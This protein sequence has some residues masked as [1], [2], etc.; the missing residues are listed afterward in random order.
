VDEQTQAREQHALVIL[1]P[2]AGRSSADEVR[3]LLDAALSA[4]HWSHEVYET[5]GDDDI[6]ALLAQAQTT[7]CD[8]VVAAGGDGTVS[9]V[10]NALV[11]TTMPLGIIPSG[12]ANVLALELGIPQN[13]EQAAQLLVQGHTHRTLDAMRLGDQHFVLQI[14]IGLDALMIQQTDRQAKRRWGRLAYL[15]TLAAQLV[16]YQPQR[17]TILIDGRRLRPR[18]WQILVANVGLLGAPPLRWGPRIEPDDGEIDL[19]IIHIRTLLDYARIAVQVLRGHQRTAPNMHYI[20]VREHVVIAADRSLPV[21]ADGEIV[22]QTP[23]R[24]SVV[25]HS[26]TLRVPLTAQP[27]S[28]QRLIKETPAMSDE[29]TDAQAKQRISD[30]LAEAV[31]QI[32]TPAQADQVIGDV[33]RATADTTEGEAAAELPGEPTPPSAAAALDDAAQTPAEH[34]PQAV[35]LEAARQVAGANGADEQAIIDAL[36]RVTA[37]DAATLPAAHERERRLLQDALLRRLGPLRTVDTGIFL[38]INRLP[39]PAVLN[40]LMQWLSAGMNRGDAVMVGL[41]AAAFFDRP[42]GGQA[43]REVLPALWL[44]A[45]TVEYPIKGVFRRRRPF[46]AIVRAIVVGKKPSGYSFPSGHSAAAFASAWLVTQHY[47]RLRALLYP[48][49]A[50][51]GFSRIYL[52]VHYPGDVATGAACGL[53]LAN[54]YRRLVRR[55][56]D[57]L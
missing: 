40:T 22:G 50:L 4:A 53:L 38:W 20:R 49:A 24:I 56:L 10:A 26:V 29:A 42:R 47:P 13:L 41:L 31:S 16:G 9:L 45:A 8:L 17:F 21:Q 7:G 57:A 19:C 3:R 1:N 25:P 51:V 43:L 37:P 6:G 2:V 39:R 46:I 55:V 12:T 44:T 15:A 34:Q 54:L 35:L 32:E 28:Q 52:G 23:V 5:R 11:G 36:Q 18:A 48:L 33:A 27:A 14:G 30:T